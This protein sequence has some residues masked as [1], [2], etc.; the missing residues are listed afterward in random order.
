MKSQQQGYSMN[1]AKIIRG[2]WQ[3]SQGH[4]QQPVTIDP[5]QDAIDCGFTTFDCGD[6]YL[7]VEELLGKAIKANPE[8]KLRIHT[9]FVPDIDRLDCID[10][11]YVERIIDRSLSRLKLDCIDL[12]QFHW[13]DWNVKN[14]L[15]A[16]DALNKLKA[17]GKIAAIGLT[18]V[19]G[20]YLKEFTSRFE[21]ASLQLQSSLFDKRIERGIGDYC[22]AKG[23]EILSYGALLGGFLSE[24]WLLKEEP[25][26]QQLENRSLVKYKLLIDSACGWSEFM[27][28]LAV[29]NALAEKYHSDIASVAIAALLQTE[30]VDSVIVGLSPHN[31][32]SQNRRLKSLPTIDPEDLQE[33]N[34]WACNLQGDVYDEERDRSSPHAKVMKYNLNEQ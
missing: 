8:K 22:R 20:Q 30:R 7:G 23:I 1:R 4:S 18:N 34:L 15:F 6:I 12:V 19:N 25:T 14:Y 13:W 21:I 29:L 26:L 10:F 27:R 9:K 2:C 3:L 5:I 16:M 31:Y 11:A 17:K 32:F 33:I 28:R 24:K